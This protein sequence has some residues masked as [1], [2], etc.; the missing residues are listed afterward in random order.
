M[1]ARP[2]TPT[3][4]CTQEGDDEIFALLMAWFSP[5]L[6]IGGF[7]YSHGLET[8]VASGAIAD[9]AGAEGVI[10][11]A[12]QDGAGRSDAILLCEAY[13]AQRVDDATRLQE[14]AALA[15]AL[16]PSRERAD[17]A[18][19]QGSA[20][21]QIVGTVWGTGNTVQG[22]MAF[23]VAVGI[24][25]AVHQ[26][27]V[28]RLTYGFLLGFSANLVSAAVRLVPLGQTDGQRLT[29]ALSPVAR[30]VAGAAI[31]ASLDDVG[32]ATIGLDL[33]SMRHEDQNVRLFRS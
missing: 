15:L 26:I 31:S 16:A 30:A 29:R 32:S 17:E 6:P 33:A 13:R 3:A 28:E 25:G 2:A 21:G 22:E 19:N 9:A 18:L 7:S 24:A 4:P 27:P 5:A 11:A 23:P 8:L 10:T 20:F 12:L 14:V 1:D